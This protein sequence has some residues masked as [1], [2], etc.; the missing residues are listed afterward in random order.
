MNAATFPG[1]VERIFSNA[2]E[3]SRAGQTSLYDRERLWSRVCVDAGMYA[4]D[5]AAKT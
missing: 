4:I 3:P 5:I 2:R 1:V